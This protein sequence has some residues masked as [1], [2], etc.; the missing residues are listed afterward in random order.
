MSPD[1]M[2]ADELQLVDVVTGEL[3][4]ARAQLDSGLASLAEATLRRRISRLEAD[5]GPVADELDAARSLLAEALWRQQRPIAAGAALDP[6]TSGSLELRRP[7][8]M[9]IEAEAAAATGDP[10]RAAGLMERVIDAIG[11]DDAWQ[12][13]AGTPSRISWPLPSPLRPAEPH[14]ARPPWSAAGPV[15]VSTDDGPTGDRS[16]AARARLEAARTAYGSGDLATGDGELS[17]ALRL[18]PALGGKGLRLF[19]PTLGKLPPA[20]RLVLYGDLLRAAGRE[21][22]AS[23]AYDR[24]ARA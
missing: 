3:P 22:E 23:A 5:G 19:R 9:L 15:S 2:S 8:V 17:I 21:A 11:V 20:E 12:L 6:I 4:L 14:E 10:D 13:R 1:D 7:I 18:D 16:G 24:A